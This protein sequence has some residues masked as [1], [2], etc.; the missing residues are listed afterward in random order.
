MHKIF[1][2]ESCKRKNAFFYP[3]FLTRSCSDSFSFHRRR[4]EFLKFQFHLQKMAVVE[5]PEPPIAVLEENAR[6]IPYK[7]SLF[8]Y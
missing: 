2:S 3:T 6:E 5:I 1:S 7:V 4:S 8:Y